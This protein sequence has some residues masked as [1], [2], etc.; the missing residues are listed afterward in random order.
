LLTLLMLWAGPRISD[1]TTFHR[2][3]LTAD[4]SILLYMSKTTLRA[5]RV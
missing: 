3:R 2:D 5:R 1:A 4:G